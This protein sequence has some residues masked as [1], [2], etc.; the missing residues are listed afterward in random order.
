MKYVLDSNIVIG[1]LNGVVH[2]TKRLSGISPAVVGIPVVVLAELVYG[3]HRSR[4][5]EA[6]LTKIDKLREQFPIIPTTV[7]VAERYGVT[8]SLL[9]AQGLTKSDFDLV[10]ACTALDVGAILV[11]ND[12]GLK[13]STIAEL[14]VED[15]LEL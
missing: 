8:R 4:K 1:A 5:K 10:I 15:W 12:A 14:E 3:A 11:T 7:S 2:V 13:D 9:Q 6:N